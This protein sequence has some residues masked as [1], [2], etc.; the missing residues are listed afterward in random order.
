MLL[1]DA[2]LA[3][4]FDDV[5]LLPGHS[6][7]LPRDANVS[8][9]LT[10]NLTLNVP[11]LSAAMDTVTQAE[12]AIAMARLGGMGI[13]HKNMSPAAQA[14]EVRRVKKAMTGVIVDPITLGPDAPLRHARTLMRENGINGLPIVEGDRVVGI[15]TNRD[16]RYERV[17]D[18]PLRNAMTHEGLVTCPPGTDLETARDLMQEH[19]V[20]K[21]LVVD[22]DR[23]L[24]G[25]ITFKDV[26]ATIRHPLAV[27]DARGRL[28]CGAA[29][30]VGGDR[31]ERI[32]ALVEAGVDVIVIDTAHG[33]SEGVLRATRAVRTEWPNL[34][35]IVGNVATFDATE[36]C[37]A[38][39][40]HAVKVG[41]G[42]GSICT[43]RVVAG[44][45]VPQLTA[46]AECARAAAKHGVPIIA[47]GGVKFSGDV[48][49]AVAAGADVV[50]AGSLF[51]G[52]DEAPGEVMLYQGRSY[53]S[54]RGMGSV[55]AMKA[56]SS[57]RYFQDDPGD[58]EADT[59]KLVPE[60][61]VGR[62]PHKGPV[63][64]TVGQLIGGL[65]AAMGY[66]GC[67]SIPDMKERARFVRMTAAGLKESHVHDVIITKEAP[68]YRME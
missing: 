43:T 21:L 30:G 49:K 65:R 66:T 60:G 9:R 44:V 47:D 23:R 55:E 1:A 63:A 42:P 67:A 14:A 41:I 37:I 24:C 28:R 26:E 59:R 25:L 3:L 53:K 40:A 12:M 56:G 35:V 34:E 22:G 64:D 36:A 15:L 57:D 4:T 33:H 29:V 13:L 54:Y 45:G 48:A 27:R 68:N 10:Q 2:P 39:G 16:L 51:A 7:I 11:I 58:P 17:L 38:A 62:V 61:I 52:T 19:R 32:A 46:I 5:L 6:T 18:Q 8:T 50:M 20:E 31:Q